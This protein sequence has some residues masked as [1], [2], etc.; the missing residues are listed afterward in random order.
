MRSS[1]SASVEVG[2]S[3]MPGNTRSRRSGVE[4]VVTDRAEIE[5]YRSHPTTLA[6]LQT[7]WRAREAA[8]RGCESAT[9]C[10]CEDWQ[11]KWPAG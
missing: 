2:Y 4:I 9:V 11:V 10:I 8:C 7:L 1:T 3:V 6:S 5:E